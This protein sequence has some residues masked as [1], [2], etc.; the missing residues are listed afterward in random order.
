MSCKSSSRVGIVLIGLD[1]DGSEGNGVDGMTGT[2]G[3][4]L[5]EFTASVTGAG[6]KGTTAVLVVPIGTT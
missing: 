2:T 5:S 3:A 1:V 6:V 4:D